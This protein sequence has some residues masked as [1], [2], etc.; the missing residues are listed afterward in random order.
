[1]KIDLVNL[2]WGIDDLPAD[3]YIELCIFVCHCDVAIVIMSCILPND[4]RNRLVDLHCRSV[5]R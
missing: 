5:P 1:M 4:S 2:I 3:G